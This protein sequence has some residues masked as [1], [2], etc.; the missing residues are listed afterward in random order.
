[1]NSSGELGAIKQMWL[2]MGGVATIIPLK[3]VKLIWP[4]STILVATKDC[5]SFTPTR[6]T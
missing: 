4:V 5:L 2:N 6:V 1:M 3:Q